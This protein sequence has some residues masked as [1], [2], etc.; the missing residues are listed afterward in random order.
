MAAQCNFIV[1]PLVRKSRNCFAFPVSLCCDQEQKHGFRFHSTAGDL[2]VS[3][4]L[5][6]GNGLVSCYQIRT[7]AT[8]H[9][10]A[11]SQHYLCG[12]T[13]SLCR[14]AQKTVKSIQGGECEHSG[15]KVDM[16]TS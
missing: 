13:C 15:S 7:R 8:S 12:D 2:L 11:H 5:G 4:E 1:G 6:F 10:R 9:Y 16:S 14:L 3:G